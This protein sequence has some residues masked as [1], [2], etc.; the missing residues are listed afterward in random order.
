[1][2]KKFIA[3]ACVDRMS[4]LHREVPALG[5]GGG[6]RQTGPGTMHAHARSLETSPQRESEQFVFLKR[7]THRDGAVVE[8]NVMPTEEPFGGWNEVV[9]DRPAFQ[10][11]GQHR[12]ACYGLEVAEQIHHLVVSE[13]MQKKRAENKVEAA[14]RKRQ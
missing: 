10:I 11:D 1:M 8:R 4:T 2:S 13:M 12:A 7:G 5:K 3:K 9:G 6:E 14:R